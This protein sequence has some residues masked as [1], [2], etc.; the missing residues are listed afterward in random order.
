MLRELNFQLDDLTYQI[1]NILRV[2][3]VSAL[4][5]AHLLHLD[6]V[7]FEELGLVLADR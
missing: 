3:S 1:P 2:H 7:S 5:Q 4:G 6:L